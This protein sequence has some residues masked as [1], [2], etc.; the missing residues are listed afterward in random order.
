M[1]AAP[2]ASR[3]AMASEQGQQLRDEGKLRDARTKFIECAADACPRVIRQDCAGWLKETETRQPTVIF[4]AKDDRG[5][6]LGAVRVSVDGKLVTAKLEGRPV[7][8]D[9]GAHHLVFEAEGFIADPQDVIIKENEKGRRLLIN[10]RHRGAGGSAPATPASVP[11][12][13]PKA[14][15]DSAQ[16][17]S[18]PV[19]PIVLGGVAVLGLAGFTYFFL[20]AASDAGCSPNCTDA[21]IDDLKS[22]VL[23]ADI[24]LGVGIAAGLG[25]GAYLLLAKPSGTASSTPSGARSTWARPTGLQLVPTRSGGAIR[26]DF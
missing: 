17:S 20:S 15:G 9:P 24:S 10:F 16:A 23:V 11:T 4:D 19:V 3:C 13:P 25:A 14:A 1:F 8:I 6:D 22:T 5:R 18:V 26:F 12:P 7:E 21:Q 2:D